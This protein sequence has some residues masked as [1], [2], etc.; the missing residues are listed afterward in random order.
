MSVEGRRVLIA[1]LALLGAEWMRL[2]MLLLVSRC[3]GRTSV[4]TA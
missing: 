1:T 2:D 4:A 3:L